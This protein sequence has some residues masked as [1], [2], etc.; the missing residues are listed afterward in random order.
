MKN[1]YE[2]LD[3]DQNATPAEIKKAYYAKS[4]KYHPDKNP[5]DKQAE[6]MFKE[7]NT[8]NET[9]S[10]STKRRD[11]DFILKYT[12]SPV[13]SAPSQNYQQQQN[14]NYK[15][16]FINELK[17]TLVE[18]YPINRDIFDYEGSSIDGKGFKTN[19]SE[20]FK[21]LPDTIQNIIRTI[22]TTTEYNASASDKDYAF[23]KIQDTLKSKLESIEKEKTTPLGWLGSIGKG[24]KPE[25]EKLYNY[26]YE[27]MNNL[28]QSAQ[29]NVQANKTS[30]KK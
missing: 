28:Q 7:V 12:T 6:E 19:Y 5:G 3:V 30:F 13:V 17:N 23:D 22:R 26:L 25:T 10:D 18:N 21:K 11:Y 16:A 20:D 4:R 15:A 14:Y 29:E 2:I 9:L 1:Y 27:R 8:A 24:R